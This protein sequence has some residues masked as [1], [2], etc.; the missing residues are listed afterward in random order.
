MSK[1]YGVS[2]KTIRDIWIGRTWYRA[3]CHLDHTQPVAPERL[4]K[5]AGR[6]K[7]VKDSKKRAKKPP[8]NSIDS[9]SSVQ[10]LNLNEFVAAESCGQ[11]LTL[12][13]Y[14]RTDAEVPNAQAV[15]PI[16]PS[17]IDPPLSMGPV[18]PEVLLA[19]LFQDPFDESWDFGL[20]EEGGDD[21]SRLD[22][23]HGAGA[24]DPFEPMHFGEPSRGVA[25]F[26]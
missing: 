9:P 20:W 23:D 25:E 15:S 21:L 5:K 24:F 11:I 4:Q 8:S 3:T 16:G 14:P 6:P 12:V 18:F 10:E 17:E 7:G 22:A 2:V 19:E 26:W 1:I 13:E